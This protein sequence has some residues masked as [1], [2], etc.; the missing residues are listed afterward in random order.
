MLSRVAERM[1]WFGRYCERIENTARLVSVYS[2]LTLDMPGLV[3]HIWSDLVAITG[4]TGPFY[5]KFKAGNERNVTRFMLTDR[6]NPGSL[7]CSINA[8][9]ENARTTREIMSAEAWEQINGLYHYVRSHGEDA[10][11]RNARHRFLSDVIRYCYQM[12]GLFFGNMNHGNAYSFI[13]MGRNLERADMATRIVDV[14]CI[15]LLQEQAH[16]PDAYDHILWMNVLRSLGA[17]QMFRQNVKERVNG[18]DVVNFLIKDMYFPRSVN[19]CLGEVEHCFARLPGHEQPLREVRQT[20]RIV[21]R[22]DIPALMQSGLH[23]F[24]DEIQIRF[25]RIHTSVGKAW[26]GYGKSQSQSR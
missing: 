2:N 3:K 11:K 9:R 18:E 16:I 6:S 19:H 1:Y 13:F 12:T 26:F 4:D 22:I 7:I 17:Y 15:N 20:E 25:A 24:I 8:A 23:E 14:G 5:R 10:L 21:N